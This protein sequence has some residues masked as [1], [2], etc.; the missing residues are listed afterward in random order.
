[1]S[2]WVGII[3]IIESGTRKRNGYFIYFTLEHE[4]CA[5]EEGTRRRLLGSKIA[6]R[7]KG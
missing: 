1:M 7:M 2:R 4:E 5:K 3:I 6:T